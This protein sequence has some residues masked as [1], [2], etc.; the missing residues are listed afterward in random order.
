MTAKP[1]ARRLFIPLGTRLTVPVVLLVAAVATGAY[2][3]VVKTS[4]VTAL[5]SKEVAADMVVKLTSL[6]VMPAVVFGDEVEIKRAVDDLARNPEVT[7]V[8]LICELRAAEV[9]VTSDLGPE[10]IKAKIAEAETAKV[11]TMLVIGGR[12]VE[13]GN[14]SVRLHGKGNVGAKPKGEVVAE[15]LGAIKERRA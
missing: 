5:R 14:V 11:H 13:A 15:I 3:G 9:R 12:D 6:S 2:F 7:D 1:V 8:E 10:P 4:R